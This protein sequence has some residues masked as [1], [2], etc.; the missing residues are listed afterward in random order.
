[1]Q[2]NLFVVC[3]LVIGIIITQLHAATMGEDDHKKGIKRLFSLQCIYDCDL[4]Y[5]CRMESLIIGACKP[6]YGCD[7]SQFYRQGWSMERRNRLFLLRTNV[8]FSCNIF[9]YQ[10][11]KNIRNGMYQIWKEDSIISSHFTSI[12]IFFTTKSF[13]SRFFLWNYRS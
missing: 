2:R 11:K 6:P 1:M 9:Q 3:L 8:I 10:I 5:Q 7:C 4:W 12:V 13:P